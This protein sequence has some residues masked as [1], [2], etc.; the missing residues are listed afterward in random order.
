MQNNNKGTT[1]SSL[2]YRD[3]NASIEERVEHL[4]TLM[5]LDEKLAQLGCLWSTT[6]VST[7]S[8]DPN[9]VAEQMRFVTKPGAFTFSIRAPGPISEPSRP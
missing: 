3:P 9:P 6:F 4:L 5:T 7:G 8:F 2:L 1:M